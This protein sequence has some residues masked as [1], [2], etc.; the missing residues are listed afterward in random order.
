ML[1]LVN[2]I[3]AQRQRRRRLL[4]VL[5]LLVALLPGLRA[6]AAE[7][8]WLYEV[9]VPVVD[10]SVGA[11]R[12][13][14]R[15]ALLVLLTRLTGL[16]NV[17]RSE[18]V[19]RALGAP[20]LFYNQFRYEAVPAGSQ[21]SA[22]GLLLHLQFAPRPVLDLVREAQLPV[23]RSNRPTVVAWLV[24]DDAVGDSLATQGEASTRHVLGADSDQPVVRGLVE[25]ARLRGLPLR[26]PL[27]DLTDQLAVAP[28]A[29]WGRLSQTLLP[30]SER[31]AADIVLVGRLQRRGDGAWASSWEAW[32]DGE[33]RELNLDDSDAARLGA[34]AADLVADD[35]V[36]RYAVLDRGSRQL[37]LSVSAV[38]G[39]ADY[40]AL[41]SYLS[42]L[43]FVDD[44][45]VTGVAGDRVD[46]TLS[47]AAQAEQLLG[48]FRIDG[49]LYDDR[50]SLVAGSDLSLVWRNR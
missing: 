8:P 38:R 31:Y 24:Q 29:V 49:R 7:V 10:Q 16:P 44:I 11:R 21:A 15:D 3:P 5:A 34:A 46:V 20:D 42:G 25:R 37:R 39:A 41:L 18:P 28:G 2:G 30:A 4:R 17:P 36:Q 47:T 33:V 35:L 1:I 40:A 13:A 26:L 27:M 32:I 6:A 48:L 43:E 14:G 9:A 12:D 50:L 19:T 23:W 22:P 45:V